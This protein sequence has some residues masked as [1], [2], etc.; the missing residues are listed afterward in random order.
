MRSRLRLTTSGAVDLAQWVRHRFPF[1]EA[2][3]AYGVLTGDVANGAVVLECPSQTGETRNT[4][5]ELEIWI[6]GVQNHG[7][8]PI[9]LDEILEVS[10][11][12]IHAGALSRR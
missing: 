3:P 4:V 1:S 12:V 9:P 11:Y 5:T 10:Q 6:K 2:H 7:P 8:A